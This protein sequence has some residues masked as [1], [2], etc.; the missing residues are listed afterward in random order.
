MEPLGDEVVVHGSTPGTLV[1]SGAE[2]ELELPLA[3]EGSRAPV[4]ARFAPEHEPEPGDTL[5]LGITPDAHPPVRS[6]DPPRDRG[7]AVTTG[8]DRGS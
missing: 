7:G 8:R 3:V 6:A 2:E 1:E 5:R 4:V